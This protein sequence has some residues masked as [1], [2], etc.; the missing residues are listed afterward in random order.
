MCTIFG[1]CVTTFDRDMSAPRYHVGCV[2]KHYL[3]T[4]E[5]HFVLVV[6]Q[7]LNK[8]KMILEGTWIVFSNAAQGD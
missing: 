3:S 7:M 5:Y 4:S 8:D 6:Y 2:R 1:K